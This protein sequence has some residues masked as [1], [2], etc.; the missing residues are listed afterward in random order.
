MSRLVSNIFRTAA[1]TLATG[2]CGALMLPPM[3]HAQSGEKLFEQC[4][5]CH[6]LE[7]GKNGVGPSLNGIV[8]RKIASV[9]GFRYSNIIKAQKLVWT[10][11]LLDRFLADPQAMFRGNKMP[12]SGISDAG[13]RRALLDWLKEAAK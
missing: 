8:G 11:E 3:S 4:V 7:A 9:D 6:S 2:L 1:F 13:L 10:D 12:F 5:T